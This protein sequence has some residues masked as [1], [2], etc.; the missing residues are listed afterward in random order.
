M[1]PYNLEILNKYTT[2]F[3]TTDNLLKRGTSGLLG[4][5]KTLHQYHS[6]HFEDNAFDEFLKY[7]AFVKSILNTR[8]HIP[9]KNK[10]KNTDTNRNA[11]LLK[12]C[13]KKY[14]M[15]TWDE[16]QVRELYNKNAG[17]FS[18]RKKFPHGHSLSDVL[19]LIRNIKFGIESQEKQKG[20]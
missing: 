12:R 4:H 19:E 10:T 2:K 6:G 16:K 13:I 9:K 15:Y 3:Q 7:K 17:K 14:K 18:Y 11:I 1:E 8:E 20:T 5:Y